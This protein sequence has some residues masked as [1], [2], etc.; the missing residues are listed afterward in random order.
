ME[1]PFQPG[2]FYVLVTGYINTV[3][4]V[5]GTDHHPCCIGHVMICLTKEETTYLSFIYGV[6]C[7]IP[8]LSKHLHAT[9]TDSKCVL[10][11]T[12]VDRFQRAAPLLFYIHSERNARAK[13]R[14]LG[15]SSALVECICQDLN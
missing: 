10:I 15:L 6:N 4:K 2:L 11:N 8:G 13:G 3:L 1:L 5:K 12:L 14:N 7:E 9:G